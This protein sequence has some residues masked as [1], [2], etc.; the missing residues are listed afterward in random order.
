M[1]VGRRKNGKNY[2][3]ISL[4]YN[5][6]YSLLKYQGKPRRQLPTKLEILKRPKLKNRIYSIGYIFFLDFRHSK[7][8]PLLYRSIL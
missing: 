3:R 4:K 5:L 2:K 1:R 7:E 8:L 6:T